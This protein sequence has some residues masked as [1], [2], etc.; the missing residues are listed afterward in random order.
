MAHH[1]SK[2]GKKLLV[3]ENKILRNICGPVRDIELNIWRGWYN[4]ELREITKVPSF[5]SYIKRQRPQRFGHA[6]RKAE[7]A[8]VRA[9]I[10]RQPTGKRT[11]G[12]I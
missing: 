9:A 2:T 10:E 8:S 4:T 7:T 1:Y 6:M 12:N 11:H 3:F 5:E